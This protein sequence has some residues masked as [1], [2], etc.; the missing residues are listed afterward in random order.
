[1][2]NKIKNV[3]QNS[4]ISLCGLNICGLASKLKLG[5]LDYYVKQFDFV[6]LSETK[7]DFIEDEDLVGFKPIV[8]QNKNN[9]QS[10]ALGGTHG[11]CV[12]IK[13]NV[14]KYVTVLSELCSDSVLWIRIKK[15]AFGCE[16][17]L[18][19][20][21]IPHEGSPHHNNE[22]FDDIADDLLICK[23]KFDCPII[24]LGDFNSRTGHVS[25]FVS[26]EDIIVDDCGIEIAGNDSF[27]TKHN[28]ELLNITTD[29]YNLDGT[30]N[31][32]G[33]KLI[34]LCKDLNLNIVNGRFGSDHG[35]GNFTCQTSAGK[36]VV[37]YAI[38]SPLLL[39]KI[40]DFYIDVYDACLSDVHS[41]VCLTINFDTNYTN[42]NNEAQAA[43]TVDS[44]IE[45]NDSETATN[46]NYVPL[47]SIWN[48]SLANEYTKSFC[49]NNIDRLDREVNRIDYNNT[50]QTEIDTVVNQLSDIFVETAKVVGICK[51]TH[52]HSKQLH[53]KYKPNISKPWFD[54]KC[55][56]MRSNYFK[57]KNK[58]QKS[59]SIEDKVELSIKGKEYKKLINKTFKEYN[60]K[61]HK[62]LRNIKNT[63]P[64]EYWNILNKGSN[65]K[66]NTA[67]VSL[68]TF[69]NHFRKI[70]QKRT[71]DIPAANEFDPRVIDHSLNEEINKVFTREEIKTSIQKSKNN[72]ACG[73]DNVITEYLK[74]CPD[75]L[76]NIIVKIFNLVLL[77][78]II[79]E[80]W[81]LGMIKPLY[82]NKG[83]AEDPDNYRGITLLSC[84]GKLFTSCINVRLSEYVELAGI[85]GEEQ[86]GFRRGYSTLDHAFVLHSLVELYLFRKKRIYC[87]FVDYKK[88]FDLVDRSSLWS[89]LIASGI[90]GNIIKVIYNLYDNAKSCIKLGNTISNFFPC[91]IGVRQGE[92]LSPLLFAI[93]LNDFEYYV[94]RGY[95][96]LDVFA[97]E[98]RNNL[99]D[100]DVEVFLRLY[101]LLYADDTIVMAE[102]AEEL[103]L[104]L[105]SVYQYCRSWYL[106]VNT[107]KTKIVIFS[108]GKVR[109][110]PQFYFGDMVIK[111]VDD[112][113]YL[114]ITFNYNGLFHKAINKQVGQARRAMFAMLTKAR[115]MCLPVDIQCELFDVLVIPIL[116][117]GSEIWGH[118]KLDQVEIFHRKFL[119]TL[120]RVHRSTANSMTYGELGRFSLEN[121]INKRLIKFWTRLIQGKQS[122]LSNLT[123]RL[124]KSLYDDEIYKSRWIK[125]IRSILDNCGLTNI[126]YEQTNVN[127]IWIT[128][129][130]NLRLKDISVQAW[131]SEVDTNRLCINYKLFKVDVGIEQY[132][133]KLDINDRINLCKYRCGSHKLPISEGRYLA[134]APVKMCSLCN[135]QDSG[136]EYH[137]VMVCPVFNNSRAKYI[138]RYYYTRPN[139]IKFS[140]LFNSRSI[141]QLRNLAKFVKEIMSSF[142]IR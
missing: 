87:A 21:Y 89:K 35:V 76:L 133:I 139:V 88:A 59:T 23:S 67:D 86:A 100:D 51:E 54:K 31:N 74:Q 28:L 116:L 123:Y 24:L 132:L 68:R 36:S 130:I 131:H 129:C 4:K 99:S 12:L 7:T 124:L 41:A 136:D 72:K 104:A 93:F 135:S 111:V 22:I 53:T 34:D 58:L 107:T 3:L 118:S 16:F 121:E 122:K 39:S 101:V 82:K 44:D 84:I 75:T 10:H 50:S 140:E 126:W 142:D 108:R 78:G 19:S 43:S 79:P 115:K 81:C 114:G 97:A 11:L 73:I 98:V 127:K 113:V 6:C 66:D 95:K 18:G 5:V 120:L 138:K 94:S 20:V 96:G 56:Q 117:Y 69:E 27:T 119:R 48:S 9:V 110:Y 64:R 105:T 62:N 8:K 109:K 61:L 40:V 32:N 13:E 90:N 47:K 26:F 125:K 46:Y 45:N 49:K 57:I 112:Y 85:L 37:D 103:Q 30:T 128:N 2:P 52:K 70:S 60:K 77:S 141:K 55:E 63:K 29:R 106:T 134:D 71:P 102:S 14:Y 17:I 80:A 137:Y 83:S 15:E 38:T 25:D 65:Y 92:N 1:M 33:H 42:V 91:N